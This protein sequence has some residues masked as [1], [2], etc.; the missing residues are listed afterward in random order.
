MRL[1]CETKLGPVK[2][3]L[4]H[5]FHPEGVVQI[6]FEE[7]Q[8]A[9]A[10]I[11]LM[12]GRFFNGRSL[13]CFYWDGQ[14]NYRVLRETTAEQQKRIDDFGRWLESNMDDLH[15]HHDPD[16]A[17]ADSDEGEEEEDPAADGDKTPEALD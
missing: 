2:K 15:R 4:V 17:A 12:H 5:E 6:K 1:E 16:A 3:I 7:P 13:E 8:A 9:E 11:A 14:T 10:C